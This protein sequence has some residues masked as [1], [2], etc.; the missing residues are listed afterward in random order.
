MSSSL[1]LLLLLV[2]RVIILKAARTSMLAS[3]RQLVCPLTVSH[4]AVPACR[5]LRRSWW[6]SLSV[7][8]SLRRRRSC[9]VWRRPSISATVR[10]RYNSETD[11]PAPTSLFSSA[12]DHVI[13]S[14]EC[15]DLFYWASIVSFVCLWDDVMSCLICSR[16]ITWHEWHFLAYMPSTQLSSLSSLT[17]PD[18]WHD[19]IWP[20]RYRPISLILDWL[21]GTVIDHDGTVVT[22]SAGIT[23]T[24]Q[25][26]LHACHLISIPLLLGRPER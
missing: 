13:S 4:T 11:W 2:Y 6:S 16:V 22:L 18:L 19:L 14:T 3:I 8:N 25:I 7:L 1:L 20:D 10:R 5:I 23:R 15:L 17:W 12:A 24:H 26:S 9:V 21:V